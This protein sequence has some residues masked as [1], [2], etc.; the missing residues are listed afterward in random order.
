VGINPYYPVI[1]VDAVNWAAKLIYGSTLQIIA[2]F[3][4]NEIGKGT[5][6]TEQHREVLSKVKEYINCNIERVASY[7]SKRTLPLFDQ[8]IVTHEYLSRRLLGVACFRKDRRGASNA[9]HAVISELINFGYLEPI[10]KN[11]LKKDYGV[12]VTAY[13]ISDSQQI[14]AG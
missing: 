14:V 1:T 3:A 13:A 8:K 4:R 12:A 11:Q 5:E 6:E 2:K 10:S 9:L 7:M